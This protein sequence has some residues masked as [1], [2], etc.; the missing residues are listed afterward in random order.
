MT[1]KLSD[2]KQLGFTLI[3]VLVAVL[4][5][6]FGLLALANLQ[7]KVHLG[8]VESYQRAQAVLLLQDLTN[9]LQANRT[10]A[11]SY[12]T[13][14]NQPVGTGYTCP[15]PTNLAAQDLCEWSGLLQGNSETLSGVNTGAMIGGRGCIEQ[16][17]A[18]DSTN[19]VC[20]PGVYRVTV[21]WQGL[22]TTS[23][24]ALACAQN[25]YGDDRYRRA[26]STLVTTGFPRCI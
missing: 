21:T 24:P 26:V 9:R 17:Q 20:T 3:E 1:M 13:G 16:I 5:L 8:Q 11:V 23:T 6:A 12:V 14:T 7:A 18:P 25:L 19:G 15:T 4:I 2:K 22:N 10:L